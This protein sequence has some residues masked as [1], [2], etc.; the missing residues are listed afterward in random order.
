MKKILSFLI[1]LCVLTALACV[2][3]YALGDEYEMPVLNN[4]N[5]TSEPDMSEYTARINGLDLKKLTPMHLPC[6]LHL[7]G[8]PALIEG[9]LS[10]DA[11]GIALITDRKDFGPAGI[12]F[13]LYPELY[14]LEYTKESGTVSFKYTLKDGK[15]LNDLCDIIDSEN[16]LAFLEEQE[17]IDDA[18][19]SFIPEGPDKCDRNPGAVRS[20]YIGDAAVMPVA[21]GDFSVRYTFTNVVTTDGIVLYKDGEKQLNTSYG[22]QSILMPL[23][24]EDTAAPV[25]TGHSRGDADMDGE[26]TILDAT[27]IQRVLA[28][29]AGEDELDK[30]AADADA[31]G[32]V[33]ILDA[34]RIQRFLAG[35]CDMDGT[36][37]E[38]PDK[39]D[40]VKELA[41]PVL[42]SVKLIEDYVALSWDE[43]EGAEFYRVYIKGGG[44]DSWTVLFDTDIN[45]LDIPNGLLSS[46]TEYSFTV[47]CV[48]GFDGDELSGCDEKGVSFMYY[49]MPEISYADNTD[50]GLYLYWNESGG[51]AAYRLFCYDNGWHKLADTEECSI[52]IT[53]LEEGEKCLFTV[54]GLD[55]EGNYIT[56]YREYG[57]P[58]TYFTEPSDV[59]WENESLLS[60]YYKEYNYNLICG[61]AETLGFTPLPDDYEGEAYHYV[62][63]SRTFSYGEPVR[64]NDDLYAR[65]QAMMAAHLRMLDRNGSDPSWFYYKILII[66]NEE[67]GDYVYYLATY[68]REGMF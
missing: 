4:N 20:F 13:G 61:Q 18:G 24:P 43:V 26:V 53:G 31:D 56:A 45:Y 44:Y 12:V 3:A 42:K 6:S 54:R 67:T 19:E 40:P 68:L 37:P 28:G 27:R 7:P 17:L 63:L 8:L 9:C 14:D 32:E 55:S 41:T 23:G 29:L 39:P 49:D 62:L 34:T 30:S 5:A 65:A 47:C 59:E 22:Y 33:T 60:D 50:E 64:R 46:G 48:D 1:A 38:Q 15:T 25:T 58:Y 52:C 10:Y 11:D 36:A 21:D 2:P 51:A 16:A 66:E 35:L 57:F